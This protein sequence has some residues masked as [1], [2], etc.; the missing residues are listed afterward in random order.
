MPPSKKAQTSK[1][2]SSKLKSVSGMMPVVQITDDDKFAMFLSVL[3]MVDPVTGKPHSSKLEME[4]VRNDYED[5]YT[6]VD[7]TD[8]ETA[9]YGLLFSSGDIFSGAKTIRAKFESILANQDPE[10]YIE[11]YKYIVL[12]NWIVMNKRFNGYGKL[13]VSLADIPAASYIVCTVQP[14]VLDLNASLCHLNHVLHLLDPVEYGT[15]LKPDTCLAHDKLPHPYATVK[16]MEQ[17]AR[18]KKAANNA[19]AAQ[20]KAEESA[21]AAEEQAA[22]KR[23]SMRKP[24]AAMSYADAL[25]AKQLQP[26][27]NVPSARKSSPRTKKVKSTASRLPGNDEGK[28]VNRQTTKYDTHLQKLGH[29]ETLRKSVTKREK[30][31]QRQAKKQAKKSRIE[32][33]EHLRLV[34]TS[35]EKKDRPAKIKYLMDTYGGLLRDDDLVEEYINTHA[36]SPADR[37]RIQDIISQAH[38]MEPKAHRIIKPSLYNIVVP[39]SEAQKQEEDLAAEEHTQPNIVVV[40]ETPPPAPDAPKTIEEAGDTLANSYYSSSSENDFSDI[41]P[42]QQRKVGSTAR[43]RETKLTSKKEDPRAHRKIESRLKSKSKQLSLLHKRGKSSAANY[44]LDD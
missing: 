5:W 41:A 29:L 1:V 18:D 19:A 28:H 26:T 23:Q 17:A 31:D 10:S 33:I 16:A 39:S 2:V 15:G 35:I 25:F 7:L 27:A 6:P 3:N 13:I 32:D 12:G 24:A 8:L 36:S 21:R 9:Y 11:F 44:T 34:L 4:K 43:P 37:E 20:A 30:L 42:V 40:T 38:S 14:P 22:L